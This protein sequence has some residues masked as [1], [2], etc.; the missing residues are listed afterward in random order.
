VLTDLGDNCGGTYLNDRYAKRLL[1]RLREE[2]Y[3][4]RRGQTR[5][6]IVNGFIPAFET[7]HKRRKDIFDRPKLRL[8]IPGL[9][10]DEERGL[11]GSAAKRFESDVMVLNL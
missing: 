8:P 9:I 6:K 11:R 7:K 1:F 5:D 10:G 4:D 3:L 2:H